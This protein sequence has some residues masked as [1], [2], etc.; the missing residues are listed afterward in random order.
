MSTVSILSRK[1]SKNSYYAQFR[2]AVLQYVT[3]TADNE[4]EKVTKQ[5]NSNNRN[6]NVYE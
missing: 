6:T 3:L 2:K 4:T 5:R 1:Y